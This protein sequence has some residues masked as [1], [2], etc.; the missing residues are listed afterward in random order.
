M[1]NKKVIKYILM[2]VFTLVVFGYNA[3]EVG[4]KNYEFPAYGR[5][6]NKQTVEDLKKRDHCTYSMP[7]YSYS[8]CI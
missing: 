3:M 8:V 7:A 5:E 4:A 1:Q 2:F 6:C